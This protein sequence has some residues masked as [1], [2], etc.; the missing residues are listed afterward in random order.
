MLEEAIAV[1]RG[2]WR[3]E[4][5]SHRGEHYTV[6]NAR[7]YTLPGRPPPIMVAAAGPEAAAL[8]GRAG[9]GLINTAPDKAVVDAFAAAGGAAKPRYAN[10]T[11]CWAADPA[12]AR[13]TAHEIWPTGGLEGALSQELPLPRHFEEAAKLVTEEMIAEAVV[14]GPDPEPYLERI[15]AYA[16]AG[17]GHLCLHQVGPDQ[18][19]FFRFFERALTPRLGDAG[20]V[21]E[22][23]D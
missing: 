2:L 14:C 15:R 3:G 6:E 18:E 13:R 1:L 16:D 12:A 22:A 4:L 20:A 19:G 7:L 5:F 11:V 8:A 23:A 17:V 10:M 9:D 21:L